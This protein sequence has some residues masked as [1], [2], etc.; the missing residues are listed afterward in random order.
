MTK[1][2]ISIFSSH[3]D[4]ILHQFFLLMRIV[5]PWW[6]TPQLCDSTVGSSGVMFWN[7]P[8]KNNPLGY[9]QL[10]QMSYPTWINTFVGGRE[11]ACSIVHN[12]LDCP[13]ETVVVF[14]FFPKCISQ[15]PTSSTFYAV[16]FSF[17]MNERWRMPVKFESI[18]KELVTFSNRPQK[19]PLSL[20]RT[21]AHP[22]MLI[23]FLSNGPFTQFII[24]SSN[25]RLE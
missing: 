5:N 13:I 6:G 24:V 19:N 18:V 14:S 10:E 4:K 23:T 20:N 25:H 3:F 22:T 15:P 16:R 11:G 1:Y 17:N 2:S 12:C 21:T 8:L 7:K 9:H